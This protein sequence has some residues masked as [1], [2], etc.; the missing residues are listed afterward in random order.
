V[1]TAFK[2]KDKLYEWLVM[3]FGLINASSTFI[4]LMNKVL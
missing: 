1:E 4:Q 2:T 3:L